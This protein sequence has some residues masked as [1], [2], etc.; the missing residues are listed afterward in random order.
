MHLSKPFEKLDKRERLLYYEAYI[1]GSEDTISNIKDFLDGKEF[2]IRLSDLYSRAKG[3]QAALATDK[4]EEQSDIDFLIDYLQTAV[5]GGFV[6]P[7]FNKKK[8]K[9]LG[10][11]IK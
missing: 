9:S 4:K 3:L 6:I 5:N 11:I 10:L 1:K 8:L 7:E 2:N